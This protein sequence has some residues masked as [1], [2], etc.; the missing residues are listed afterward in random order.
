[1]KMSFSPYRVFNY[2]KTWGSIEF[3]ETSTT[4]GMSWVPLNYFSMYWFFSM[5]FWYESEL[6][7]DA[8][9]MCVGASDIEI[10]YL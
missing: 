8:L 7:V 9:L 5:A 2:S 1:M 10:L 6:H 4:A 3:M